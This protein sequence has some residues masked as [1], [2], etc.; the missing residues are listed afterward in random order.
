MIVNRNRQC[1]LRLVLSDDIIIQ[2][3]LD[4]LR[5]QKVDLKFIRLRVILKF[6]LNDLRA[7]VH[8]LVTDVCS[9]GASNELADLILRLVAEG[10]AHLVFTIFSCHLL[11]SCFSFS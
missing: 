7:N 11:Y 1:F 5:F 10:A 4:L 6:L 2:E 3:L 8:T 9:V